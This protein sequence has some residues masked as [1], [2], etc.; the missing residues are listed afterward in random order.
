MARTKVSPTQSRR[1]RGALTFRMPQHLCIPGTRMPPAQGGPGNPSLEEL[2]HSFH[3]DLGLTGAKH[4]GF[5]GEQEKMPALTKLTI[6]G[7]KAECQQGNVA[8]MTTEK[9]KYQDSDN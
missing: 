7:R 2:I 3:R 1:Q 4:S 9:A 6:C 8:K 5:R